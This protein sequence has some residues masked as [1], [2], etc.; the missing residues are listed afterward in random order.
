MELKL[1]SAVGTNNPKIIL[2]NLKQRSMFCWNW[3]LPGNGKKL[4]S[5]K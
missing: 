3:K 5:A 1:L 4:K 2:K